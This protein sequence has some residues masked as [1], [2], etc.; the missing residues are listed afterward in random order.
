MTG[1]GGTSPAGHAGC[2]ADSMG[3]CAGKEA[4]GTIWFSFSSNCRSAESPFHGGK[5]A[6]GL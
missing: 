2:G 3:R 4:L 5:S 1:S 6:P